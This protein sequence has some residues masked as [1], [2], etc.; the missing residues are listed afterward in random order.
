MPTLLSWPLLG[1]AP[2]PAEPPA[3]PSSSTYSVEAYA[4]QL[5]ELLPRGAAFLRE[6]ASWTSKVLLGIAEELARVDSRGRDLLEE[7][8]PRTTEELLEDWERVLGL[9]DEGEALGAT[10]EERRLAVVQKLVAR[11]GQSRAF[12]V[13]LALSIGFV[14]TITEF[15]ADVLRVG[16]RVG[17]RVYGTAWSHAWQVDVDLAASTSAVGYASDLLEA[18]IGRAKPA[19]STV[20]FVYT[21]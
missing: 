14:V 20:I 6:P 17:D 3:P 5:K 7:W 15:H 12:F 8:D 10:L 18:A 1:G 16:F 9:P 11:G 13:A 19:H 2:P 4:R 21:P